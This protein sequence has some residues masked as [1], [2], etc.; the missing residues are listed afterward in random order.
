MNELYKP[1]WSRDSTSW[2]ATAS[3][4]PL[5]S[6]WRGCRSSCVGRGR[7]ASAHWP[8]G[9]V[10]A[11]ASGRPLRHRHL[12]W[13]PGPGETQGQQARGSAY[14]PTLRHPACSSPRSG[15]RNTHTTTHG[16]THTRT[17]D[18]TDTQTLV[19]DHMLHL[20]L[21][22]TQLPRWSAVWKREDGQGW[23]RP[24][25]SLAN[26]DSQILSKNNIKTGCFVAG[27]KILGDWC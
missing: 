4:P 3:S 9:T 1:V 13:G 10:Y 16:T 19:T 11:A 26:K 5:C 24:K 21:R 17:T 20:W 22:L 8:C 6:P 7:R 2:A 12:P 23:T 18:K 27:G 15:V 14:A 25:R